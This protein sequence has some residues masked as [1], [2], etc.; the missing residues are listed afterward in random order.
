MFCL[1][2]EAH[3][4]LM[5]VWEFIFLISLFFF[6]YLFNAYGVK[7]H[8]WQLD[9]A[10]DWAS[11]G[12][13][14]VSIL[15]MWKT[16]RLIVYINLLTDNGETATKVRTKKTGNNGIDRKKLACTYLEF[17]TRSGYSF[18]NTHS[19]F[20]K[21]TVATHTSCVIPHQTPPPLHLALPA[22]PPLL[23]PPLLAPV[24]H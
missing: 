21:Q 2:F 10:H 12:L 5:F 1:F 19:G 23:S 17:L 11:G 3:F 22:F 15:Q 14:G 4:Q 18:K 6:S 16:A 9:P 8:D 20:Q 13:G 24:W 7:Y